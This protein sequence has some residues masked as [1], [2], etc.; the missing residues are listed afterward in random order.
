MLKR[1]KQKDLK[2]FLTTDPY[3]DKTAPFE[4]NREELDKTKAK[5]QGINNHRGNANRKTREIE[6]REENKKF[7]MF[8]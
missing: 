2:Q 7:G 5:N 8:G 1:R 6:R 3:L 4:E